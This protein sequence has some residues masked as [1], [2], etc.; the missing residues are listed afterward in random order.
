M[1]R[2]QQILPTCE[3]LDT[4]LERAQNTCEILK[5]NVENKIAKKKKKKLNI[6]TRASYLIVNSNT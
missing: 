2:Q 4:C 5:Y 6:R 3:Q 1:H